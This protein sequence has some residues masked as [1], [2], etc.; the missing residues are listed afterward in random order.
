MK[1]RIITA[2]LFILLG[3]LI[4]FGPQ[5]L[6]P[7]CGVHRAETPAMQGTKNMAEHTDTQADEK[8][9]MGSSE[10]TG[11][12]SAMPGSNVMKCHWTAQ[13]ELGLG[14]LIALLGV[15]LLLSKSGDV[16]LGLSLSLILNGLLVLIIPAVLV[17]VCGSIHMSCRSLTLPALIIL[18]SAVVFAA[19]ANVYY[20]H[21]SGRK[22]RVGL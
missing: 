18:S 10:G 11:A 5:S 9:N 13:I 16:R 3:G 1:N 6:F 12:Q 20:L 15:L 2:I 19:A 17:G 8:M 4:A 21:H 22:G 14:V 7:V